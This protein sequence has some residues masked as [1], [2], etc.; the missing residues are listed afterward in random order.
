MKPLS[1]TNTL[2]DPNNSISVSVWKRCEQVKK[3]E[4]ESY[5]FPALK[6]TVTNRMGDLYRSSRRWW[7]VFDSVVISSFFVS[8]QSAHEEL[9]SKFEIS[10]ISV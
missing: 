8:D 7:F 2:F 10:E 6:D 3:T 4:L 5:L 9:C 1:E